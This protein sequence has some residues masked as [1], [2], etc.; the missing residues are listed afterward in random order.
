MQSNRVLRPLL[1]AQAVC[2]A[3]AFSTGA[4]A[5]QQGHAD[6]GGTGVSRRV[7]TVSIPAQPLQSALDAFAT[8]TGLQVVYP[9]QLTSHGLRSA[10]FAGTLPEGDI[11]NRL[12]AP[13]GLTFDFVNANTVVV[14]SPA[15]ASGK[16]TLSREAANAPLTQR[17]N[18]DSEGATATDAP[19]STDTAR[20]LSSVN[21][22]GTNLRDID[23]A[24]PLIIIDSQQI[25]NRGYSSV[26][27]VLR[28]LPQNFSSISSTS[29]ALGETEY[30]QQYGPQS[31][32][33]ASSV[34]L[35]GLG[36]RSTL[37]LV[38]GHRLAGSAQDQGG[39]TDI[40]SIP[41]S[42]IKSI[43][44]LSD[45][46][47]AIYGADAVAGVVNIVLKRSYEGTVVHLR[48]EYSSSGADATRLDL[49]HT[50][51]WDQGFLTATLSDRRTDPADISRYIH[52]G[53][54]G[55][56]DFSDIG[57]VNAG[58]PGLGQPGVVFDSFDVG[59]YHIRTVPL[60]IIPGG[61]N[62]TDL[63]PGDLLP[64]SFAAAPTS[65]HERRI[66]PKVDN[67][68][69]RLNGEQDFA[70]DLRL[71]WS[72]S[73]AR[74]K[75]SEY[76]H[77]S[78]FDFSFLE[79]GSATYVPATNPYN[80][81][82]KDVMV[83]YSYAKELSGMTFSQQQKQTNINFNVGLTGKLPIFDGWGFDV[84]YAG[85]RERGRANSLGDF[86]GSFGPQG[87]ARTFPVLNNLNVFG[88]GS[89]PRVVQAN[90][91]LLNTLVDT[92]TST[93][94]SSENSLKLLTRG[95][96]FSLPAGK[97]QMAIGAEYRNEKYDY[98]NQL[99]SNETTTSK[100]DSWSV[101]TEIG[102]PLLKDV[103]LA[104]ELTLT[105]AARYDAFDQHG[106][107]QVVQNDYDN[108]LARGDFDLRALTGALPGPTPGVTGEFTPLSRSFS[109]TSPEVKLTWRPV[110]SL[111]IRATWGRSFLTPQMRQEFGL[112]QI[113]DYTAAVQ[114]NGGTLPPGVTSVLS[115]SGPNP[116]LKPQIATVKTL[117]FDYAPGFISG[118]MIS[119]TYNDTD[120]DNYIGAPLAGLT[121]AQIFSNVDDMP[122][123]TFTKGKNGVLL[124]D[125]RNINFLGRQSRSVDTRISYYFGNE[126]VGSWRLEWNA[127][128][129][130]ELSSRSV[131]TLP[132]TVFSDSELGPSK[133]VAD[134]SLNWQKSNFTATAGL[135]YISPFRVIKPL[136]AQATIYN[137]FV[138]NPDPRTHASS[139][140]TMDF[141]VGYNWDESSGWLNG[142]T[143]RL[144][145]K[146]AFEREFP[147]VD[148]RF[149]FVS[150]RASV[151]GRV[152]Y[153]DLNTNF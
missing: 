96:L 124:W 49:A 45:G 152:I 147:F 90:R 91:D 75:D 136:S 39:F 146:N 115:L 1:L 50:F 14:R 116:N 82:G 125:A 132:P 92:Y 133:W 28:H 6:T 103:P 52:V 61:Q 18:I 77:P 148:N 150:T 67:P 55:E 131:S 94:D 12:L 46:A 109:S 21:V 99:T 59:G 10:A 83:G 81:F 78:A 129:T 142:T 137:N 5:Q 123:G 110:N 111:K 32:V 63:Q 119:A 17:V 100:R 80:H 48:H 64:Y 130:L 20:T 19:V 89:D 88:D 117:G 144:G 153:L 122:P 149:G 105:L 29:V 4:L 118:L 34:N 22:T 8:Q 37:V 138:P 27:D 16:T 128:R 35:R 2:L 57:G 24:S 73:Y 98:K 135:H 143:V 102:I 3:L 43:E 95:G 86:T 40:S 26:E 11:L 140:T 51:N 13:S 120:F 145:V 112:N 121:Y 58:S 62:G 104:K 134:L 69:I 36:S 41:I 79:D 76:W 9:S 42:Q 151:R 127:V 85:S 107:N 33:G 53:P 139:Y 74:Q 30:G 87:H 47:S 23:S 93:F 60:G 97:V 70:H 66:G 68:A 31:T 126:H 15:S 101:F 108:L 113:A 38:N 25:K 141:Q 71:T 106:S 54:K 65:Y 56:G 72:A 84:S 7:V 114:Y 44:V